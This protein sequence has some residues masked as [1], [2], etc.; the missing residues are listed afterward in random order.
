MWQTVIMYVIVLLAAG[1]AVWYLVRK[2]RALRR[3]DA[4][5]GCG[6]CPLKAQCRKPEKG[7]GCETCEK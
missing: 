3:N 4:S 6:D 2:L 1:G 7:Q 5:G